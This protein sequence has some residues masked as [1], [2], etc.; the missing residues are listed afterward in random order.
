M[1]KQPIKTNLKS[2]EFTKIF[3]DYRARIDEITKKTTDDIEKTT[4]A[5]AQDIVEDQI[6]KSKE[7][8][9]KSTDAEIFVDEIEWQ[10]NK[11]AA[12]IIKE[13]KLQAQRLI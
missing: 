10:A 5:K 1:A 8:L 4:K 3:D 2:D 6:N 7:S 9:D 11:H 13:A 12:E